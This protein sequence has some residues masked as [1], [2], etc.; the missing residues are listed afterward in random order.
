MSERERTESGMEYDYDF[1]GMQGAAFIL[2]PE[3]YH[4]KE[5]VKQAKQELIKDRDVIGAIKV[6]WKIPEQVS[7]PYG[8]GGCAIVDL[9]ELENK[10]RPAMQTGREA[11]RKK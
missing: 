2:F 5:D 8:D 4:T 9:E 10:A 1:V 11:R 7:V 3:T 6:V